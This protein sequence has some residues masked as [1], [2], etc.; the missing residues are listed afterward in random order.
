M[1]GGGTWHGFRVGVPEQ[2]IQLQKQLYHFA[3]AVTPMVKGCNEIDMLVKAVAE[4]RGCHLIS[5]F[6][7]LNLFKQMNKVVK[8]MKRFNRNILK[9][10]SNRKV[11]SEIYSRFK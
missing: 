5:P 10:L 8:L 7:Y 9:T 4:G 11:N 2:R 1:L 6:V 3:T